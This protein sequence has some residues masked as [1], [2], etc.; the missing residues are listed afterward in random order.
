[1]DRNDMVG[2]RW[3]KTYGGVLVGGGEESAKLGPL[4]S[5]SCESGGPL[6]FRQLAIPRDL[7][8][9]AAGGGTLS[10]EDFTSAVSAVLA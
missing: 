1:M 4:E 7:T 3:A 9:N 8:Q 5:G 2:A 10:A 6:S